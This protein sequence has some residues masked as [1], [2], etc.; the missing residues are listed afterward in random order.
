[1]K[2]LILSALI[3][4]CGYFAMAQGMPVMDATAEAT[5]QQNLEIQFALK[6]L[7]KIAA[8]V[9]SKTQGSTAMTAS[10]VGTGV[11]MAQSAYS[12]SISNG[13]EAGAGAAGSSL[14]TTPQSVEY[15]KK[16]L[17][18][19]QYVISIGLLMK[20]Y[21]K[22]SSPSKMALYQ[23]S[24]TNALHLFKFSVEKSATAGDSNMKISMK[25]RV[26]ILGE[27]SDNLDQTN[28]ILKHV[29]ACL[30]ADRLTYRNINYKN[31]VATSLYK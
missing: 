12:T 15:Y 16:V 8:K 22:Y 25:E 21:G 19:G 30:N 6:A 10:L 11:E 2:I 23:N 13:K 9:A 18:T 26:D 20:E 4:F 29:V 27:S 5:S 24:L 3:V 31:N 7:S 1:M 14:A 17:K 28:G